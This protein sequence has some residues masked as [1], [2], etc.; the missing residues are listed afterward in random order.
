M[1]PITLGLIGGGVAS[2]AGGIFGASKKSEADEQA[3]KSQAEALKQ[4]LALN[5]PDVEEQ[6][7]FLQQ[8]KSEG[9]LSPELEQ[10]ITAPDSLMQGVAVDPALKAAQLEALSGLKN[11]SDSGGHTLEDKANLNQAMNEIGAVERGKRDA[12][13]Q[14]MQQRG[15]GGSGLELAAKLSNQQAAATSANQVGLQVAADMQKRALEA[16]MQRGSL[17]GDVRGQEFGEQSDKAKAQDII[18][19]YNARN[20][21]DVQQRN[22][23]TKNAASLYNLQEKQRISDTNTGLSNQQ[24]MHNKGLI[25]KNFENRA[26]KAG[27][28]A[29]QYQQTAAQQTQ[30]G[31]DAAA[32]WSGIGSGAGQAAMTLADFYNKKKKVVGQ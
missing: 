4:W 32:M 2:L 3:A 28:T 16:L 29:G 20:R 11:I 22:V 1:D 13:M 26:T 6:K 10:A 7:I 24:E 8:L 9:Q 23:D 30:Q 27:G 21:Q 25:Q 12:I 17:A 18:N 14:S 19:A 5:I 31:N 15:V